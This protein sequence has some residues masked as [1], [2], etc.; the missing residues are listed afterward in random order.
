MRAMF[1]DDQRLGL[2]QIEHLSRCVTG[3]RV[4]RQRRAAFGAGRG[5]MIFDLVGFG[6]LPQRLALV[7]LLPARFSLGFLAQTAHARRLF[8]SIARRRL[9]A[10]GTVQADL[11]L[12]FGDPS[13]QS[14]VF[15]HASC[16]LR[17]LRPDQRNQLFP[18]RFVR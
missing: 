10:V 4:R 18:R 5:K 8:Q 11:A 15:S 13:L 12:K 14:R 3:A 6:D 7:A 17:R 2:R 1:G 9:A 16:D